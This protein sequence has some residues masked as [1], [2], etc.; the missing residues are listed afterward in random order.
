MYFLVH[1]L[2]ISAL[3]FNPSTEFFISTL[4]TAH[5]LKLR[6]VLLKSLYNRLFSMLMFDTYLF[7]FKHIKHIMYS[8]LVSSV[9]KALFMLS[10][11]ATGWVL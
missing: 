10:V 1:C 5:V 8:A 9:F 3:L 2:F 6:L 7:F 4:I 11:V